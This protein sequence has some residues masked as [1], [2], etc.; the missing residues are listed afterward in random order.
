MG[1]SSPS[2]QTS[3]LLIQCLSHKDQWVPTFAV[4]DIFYSGHC[5]QSPPRSSMY[6]CLDAG[7][8]F[9]RVVYR[10]TAR[11]QNM[12]S[13]SSTPGTTQKNLCNW[14]I[15]GSVQQ[16]QCNIQKSLHWA[17]WENLPEKHICSP[18]ALGKA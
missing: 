1:K 8:N 18:E 14:V 17:S 4:I 16:Y 2:V 13:T 15:L 11:I 3:Y 6:S 12:R 7:Q 9:S 10:T 5:Q